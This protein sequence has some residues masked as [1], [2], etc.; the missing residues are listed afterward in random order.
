MTTTPFAPAAP[1]RHALTPVAPRV[2]VEHLPAFDPDGVARIAA[3]VRAT[4]HV[5]AG[6]GSP[7]GVGVVAGEH[8]SSG[9]RRGGAR[10]PPCP[11]RVGGPP[12]P[13]AAR[14]PVPFLAGGAGRTT[15]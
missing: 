4:V 7:A 10:P 3:Q 1:V 9:Y 14:G 15:P 11:G 5:V 13:G 8:A 6:H 2:P 12:L